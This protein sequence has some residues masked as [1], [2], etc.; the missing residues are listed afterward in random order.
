MKWMKTC[1]TST[2]VAVLVNGSPTEEF[3]PQRG[4]RQGDPLSS[5]LF[6]IVAE[7]LNIL[8]DRAKEIG[9]IKGVVIGNHVVNVMHL[10][11]AD[12]TILFCEAEWVEV[13]TI[14]RILRCFELISGL[15]IN[16]NKSV[17]AGIGVDEE[18]MQAFASL[19]NCTLLNL[20]LKYLGLPLG[21]NPGRKSTWKPVLDR[22]KKKLPTWKRRLLSFAG[23]TDFN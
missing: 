4:L 13:V 20:P 12:D 9:L 8:F 14:K 10:Q 3:C 11:F 21:A 16:Y 18:L 6:N 23:E 1:V 19:L 15:K 5:F 7:G 22:F 17:I 2:K